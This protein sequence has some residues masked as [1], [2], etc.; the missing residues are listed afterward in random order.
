M[1]LLKIT[2]KMSSNCSCTPGVACAVQRCMFYAELWQAEL[3]PRYAWLCGVDPVPEGFPAGGLMLE[4][5]QEVRKRLKWIQSQFVFPTKT[6]IDLLQRCFWSCSASLNLSVLLASLQQE[7]QSSILLAWCIVFT[8]NPFSLCP[9]PHNFPPAR[10]FILTPRGLQQFFRGKKKSPW[11]F[12]AS[13][14]VFSILTTVLLGSPNCATRTSLTV[15]FAGIDNGLKSGYQGISIIHPHPKIRQWYLNKLP[16]L[17]NR[18]LDA[19]DSAVLL[20]SVVLESPL[21]LVL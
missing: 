6:I 4:F 7:A 12:V 15:F 3:H 1:E 19:S 20:L 10:W 17:S 16:G 9:P 2:I 11:L 13:F 14:K 21:L 18:V 5:P 8:S